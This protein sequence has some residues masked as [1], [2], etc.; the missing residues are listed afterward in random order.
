[1]QSRETI[2]LS[3]ATGNKPPTG[4]SILLDQ[5]A[6]PMLVAGEQL[7]ASRG[8]H[9]GRNSPAFGVG[10]RLPVSDRAESYQ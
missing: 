6:R 1:M 3:L 8:R 10:H 9:H 7:E 4:W 2:G 5:T